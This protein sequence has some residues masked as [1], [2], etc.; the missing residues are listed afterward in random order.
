MMNLATPLKFLCLSAFTAALI[1]TPALAAP[2]SAPLPAPVAEMI[3]AAVASGNA[4]TLTAVVETAKKTNP[5]AIAEIDALT[6]RFKAETEARHKEKLA[7]Q[8]A[9]DGWKGQGEAG[10]ANTTG[11]TEGTNAALGL[12]FT[13]EG[14]RWDQT[15][16]ITADYQRSDGVTTKSRYFAAYNARYKFDGPF[17]ATGLLSWENNRFAGFRRRLTESLGFGYTIIDSPDLTLSAEGGPA[18]RQTRHVEDNATDNSIALRAAVRNRWAILPTLTFTEDFSYYADSRNSTIVSETALNVA[19]TG[20]LSA[21]LSYLIQYESDP[22]PPL[23]NTDTLTR[24][25]LVYS[26]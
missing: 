1:A 9:L 17:Y 7:R 19:L 22:P 13:R 26:F 15:F 18:L 6:A 5:D 10:A 21:R 25:T 4:I 12:H 20:T 14:L 2:I 16:D 23:E 11:N 3:R 24:L 8:E